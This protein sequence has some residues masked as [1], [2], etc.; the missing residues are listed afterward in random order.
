MTIKN[1]PIVVATT[2]CVVC[3]QK[4]IYKL[5]T[6]KLLQVHY[7]DVTSTPTLSTSRPYEVLQTLFLSVVQDYA[8]LEGL[9][10]PHSNLDNFSSAMAVYGRFWLISVYAYSN[11]STDLRAY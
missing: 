8:R 9:L 7:K 11:N 10:H 3:C 4:S 5:L 6:I 1:C 2:F